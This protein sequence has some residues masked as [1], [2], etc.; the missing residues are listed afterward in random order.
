MYTMMHNDSL[1]SHSDDQNTL[2]HYYNQ[3]TQD[4]K[5]VR[6]EEVKMH[7]S[8]A[9]GS[10][11]RWSLQGHSDFFQRWWS[12][13]PNYKLWLG[14]SY[15]QQSKQW[16]VSAQSLWISSLGHL[17]GP[18]SVLLTTTPDIRMHSLEIPH[19]PNLSLCHLAK[20]SFPDIIL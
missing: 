17:N 12:L 16:L 1:R 20:I 10:Q 18:W 3:N 6:L 2:A 4:C 15:G 5:V 8:W 9:L 14:M 13:I 7:C 11:T 19:C